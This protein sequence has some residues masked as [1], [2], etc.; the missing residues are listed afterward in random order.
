MLI[1]TL[2]RFLDSSEGG[3]KPGR[4]ILEVGVEQGLRN[5]GF[6]EQAFLDRGGIF[7][8]SREDEMQAPEW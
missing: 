6:D 1:S 8:W 5:A 4:S 7:Q 3:K 2:C